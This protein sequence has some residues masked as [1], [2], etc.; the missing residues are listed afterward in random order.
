M[1][2]A[3]LKKARVLVVGDLA[4]VPPFGI[5]GAAVAAVVAYGV[6]TGSAAWL[7]RR[8]GRGDRGGRDGQVGQVGRDG[9][10]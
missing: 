8:G 2:F 6:A 7:L 3:S 4:L 5:D 9:R 10:G 1:N